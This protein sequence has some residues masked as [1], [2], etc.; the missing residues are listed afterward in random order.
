M[1]TDLANTFFWIDP[2]SGCGGVYCVQIFPFADG[3]VVDRYLEFEALI[4]DR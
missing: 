1:T 3:R 4:Y 2:Q